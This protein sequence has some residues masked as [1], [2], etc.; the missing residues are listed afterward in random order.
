MPAHAKICGLSTNETLGVALDNKARWIGFVIFQ[1]SPRHIAVEKAASLAAQARGKADI[2]AVTVN[3]D[4]DLLEN[5]RRAIA[6]DFLQLH[7]VETPARARDVRR[8]ARKGIIKAF[9]IA[10]AEDFASVESYA[11]SADLFLF[12]AKAGALPGGNGA[13]F[14]WTLLQG[15]TFAKPWILSGGLT[16]DNVKDAIAATGAKAVDVSSGVERAP[17]LKDKDAIRRFLV[18]V[19]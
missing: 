2:V 11:D 9:S 17:G 1:K 3:A 8:F 19:R 14:D 13:A 7:G 12:D 18:A 4:D 16:P 10:G 15:R 5:I 6:P